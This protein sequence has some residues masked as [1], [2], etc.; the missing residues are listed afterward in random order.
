MTAALLA[1]LFTATPSADAF[2]WCSS[3]DWQDLI[4]NAPGDYVYGGNR[5]LGIGGKGSIDLS[6][7]HI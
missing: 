7:I 4:D 3:T 2:G 6:L 1:A 5:A